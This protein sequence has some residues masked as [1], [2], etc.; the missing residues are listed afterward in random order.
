MVINFPRDLPQA[1][2][3]SSRGGLVV[4]INIHLKGHLKAAIG[5]VPL[6]R[7]RRL[8]RRTWV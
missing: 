3:K 7:R 4:L 1:W 6:W 5:H 8:G 2:Q